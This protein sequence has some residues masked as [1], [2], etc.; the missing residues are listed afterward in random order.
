MKAPQSPAGTDTDKPARYENVKQY[1]V[2]VSNLP[3]L[4]RNVLNNNQHQVNI[5]LTF[6]YY[7]FRFQFHCACIYVFIISTVYLIQKTG[8]DRFVSHRLQCWTEP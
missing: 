7:A 4:G 2:C 6:L 3:F 8:D 1:F 5:S